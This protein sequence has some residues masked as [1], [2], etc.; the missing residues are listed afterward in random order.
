MAIYINNAAMSLSAVTTL[1]LDSHFYYVTYLGVGD[2]G[3][4]NW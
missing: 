2:W 1:I 4:G 3:L